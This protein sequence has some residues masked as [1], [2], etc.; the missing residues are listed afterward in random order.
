MT[1]ITSREHSSNQA[2][3]SKRNKCVRWGE[4]TILE[5]P[6]ILG[7]NPAVTNGSP[8]TIGWKHQ[9]VNVVDVEFFEFLRQNHPRRSRRELLLKCGDRD[10]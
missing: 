10:S 4:I 7:D 2:R 9:S 1:K 8:I 5:F 6:N 3:A